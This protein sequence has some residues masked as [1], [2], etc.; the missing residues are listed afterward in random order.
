[1]SGELAGRL[2]E[3]VTVERRAATRDALGGATG[4][5]IAVATIRA[6]VAPGRAGPAVAG[7]APS[8]LD[9]WIVTARAEADVRVGD[10]LVWRGRRLAAVRVVRDPR[11]PDRI[12]IFN[13]EER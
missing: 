5:W 13:E 1:M 10:R 7:D 8:G 3:R 12:E 11:A 2:R 4:A 6:A 9:D